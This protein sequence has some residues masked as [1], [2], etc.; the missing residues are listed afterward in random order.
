[1]NASGRRTLK[2]PPRPSKFARRITDHREDRQNAVAN[3]FE[4][5]AA[6]GVD[7][8]G[9]AIEPGI[10]CRDDNGRRIAF[11]ELGE[12]AQ[13]GEEERRE[14]IEALG[15]ASG[16]SPA[17]VEVTP[18][19]HDGRRWLARLPCKLTPEPHF[20]SHKSLL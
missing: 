8:A 10:E 7:R 11:G 18:S 16:R 20:A 1:M 9:D 2:S 3:K 19:N 17:A 5:F 12:P 4:H 15:F 13:I 14:V 6:E